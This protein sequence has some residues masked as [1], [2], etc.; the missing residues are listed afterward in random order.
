MT[1]D[2]FNGLMDAPMYFRRDGSPYPVGMAGTLAW[3]E[4]F[5]NLKIRR[6]AH[7]ELSNG[8]LVSTIWLG[9]DQNFGFN[10]RPLIFETMVF[11][12]NCAD[13]DCWRYSTEEEAVRGHKTMV[14]RWRT[15]KTADDILTEIKKGQARE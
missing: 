7:E 10:N 13:L 5:A 8:V 9:L 1:P 6:V 2:D 11:Y 12:K 14:K 3:A 15:Y 4:D